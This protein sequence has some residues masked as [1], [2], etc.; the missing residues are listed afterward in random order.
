MSAAAS[1]P[2]AVPPLPTPVDSITVMERVLALNRPEAFTDGVTQFDTLS[3]ALLLVPPSAAALSPPAGITPESTVS[4]AR[5]AYMKLAA[6][7]QPDK[8]PASVNARAT[9]AFQHLV[10]AFE[11]FADGSCIVA[12]AT[13]AA[14]QQKA[15]QKRKAVAA[16]KS[17]PNASGSNA[18]AAATGQ[19][20]KLPLAVPAV[21][22]PRAPR[23]LPP[24]APP[25]AKAPTP[26]SAVL[27]CGVNT[28]LQCPKCRQP[29]VPDSPV[30]Y[31][32]V[33]G[34]NFKVHCDTCLFYFG[35]ATA[36]H[37]CPMCH[38]IHGDYDSSMYG[39]GCDCPACHRR[40]VPRQV[41]VPDAVLLEKKAE[42]RNRLD[43]EERDRE[44]A[45]RLAQ[46]RAGGGDPD[47]A[48]ATSTTTTATGSSLPG[49]VSADELL[50]LIGKCMVE[51][52]CPLC[53]KRVGSKHRDHV[54]HC[55]ANPPVASKRRRCQVTIVKDADD[56]GSDDDGGGRRKRKPAAKRRA[57]AKKSTSVAPKKK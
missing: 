8:L 9:D 37:Q 40:Y 12:A 39:S 36:R 44:R 24:S 32:L 55:L 52:Q 28:T 34:H 23:P 49:G 16:N 57:A 38:K 14:A 48:G 6:M 20:E 45:Q 56:S 3:L 5:R 50:E 53:H 7:I 47:D 46:R 54:A 25:V 27:S 30:L 51:E 13:A 43:K 31:G 41:V 15:T 21:V 29:W 19:P 11:S 26:P 10:K 22:A 35:A 1:V 2:P 17:R 33:M 42:E 4:E 18:T